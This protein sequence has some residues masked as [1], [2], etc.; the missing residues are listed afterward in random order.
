MVGN[1]QS[2][3][4]IVRLSFGGG[5]VF[6]SHCLSFVWDQ[7]RDSHLAAVHFSFSRSIVDNQAFP[8]YEYDEEVTN[9][10]IML[11]HR[12]LVHTQ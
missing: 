2:L 6:S 10:I 8:R 11:I 5:T 12:N 9:I 7:S 4:S 1:L 3:G